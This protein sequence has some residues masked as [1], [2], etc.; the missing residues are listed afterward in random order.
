MQDFLK[1]ELA[2]GDSVLMISDHSRTF[3]LGRIA[4]FT[5]SG[6]RAHVAINNYIKLQHS[7]QLVKVDGPDLTAYLLKK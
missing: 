2:I 6:T 5:P 4:K 3:K 7:E 1:R